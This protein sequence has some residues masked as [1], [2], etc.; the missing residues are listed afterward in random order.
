M[1]S[2]T[3]WQRFPETQQTVQ[4]LV[5]R[6]RQRSSAIDRFAQQLL[7]E[8][9]TRI[10]DWIDSLVIHPDNWP[11][12]QA[13]QLGFAG[14][15]ASHG[16]IWRHS[17]GLFPVIVET[18]SA[19][20]GMWLRTDSVIEF[21][22]AMDAQSNPITGPPGAS[23]R[24]VC[25]ADDG[26][27]EFGAIERHGD[28][29]FDTQPQLVS[30]DLLTE[31]SERFVLRRRDGQ[32]LEE[33]F[34]RLDALLS[35]AIDQLGRDRACDLFF[36]TERHYWERRNTAAR[37]Q[38]ARQDRLGLGWSNHDHHTYRSSRECFANLISILERLGLECRERFYAG[39]EAG[40]GAQVLE[41]PACRVVV[42]ADV[43]LSADEVSGDFAHEPLAPA[44]A[45][46]TVGLWC[47][48]HGEALFEAGM[49]H[50]ECQFAFAEQR[51]QMEQLGVGVMNPFTDFSYLKQAFTKGER[52]VVA[53]E[54]IAAL[55]REGHLDA[56]QAAQMRQ[57]GAV[58]SHLEILMREE[59]F[60]GF[61]QT[62]ISDIIRKTDPRTLTQP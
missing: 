44:D 5:D 38:R 51:R 20:E 32:S 16:R 28:R 50:L 35:E 25:V 7:S 56:E 15:D 31:W 11:A 36:Q 60:K 39:R 4:N 27:I 37:I 17:D 24:K 3:V 13:V 12:D 33:R 18:D 48:L 10:F 52:W 34:Q 41:Q 47:R 54:R 21:A 22:L 23:I 40:W 14:T 1:S 19:S 46:G 57:H 43:D 6:L 8:T 53:E 58:G 49:H 61:N 30:N 42:F 29:G 45:L 62:G 59:G 26:D 55:Q 9:G 2:E